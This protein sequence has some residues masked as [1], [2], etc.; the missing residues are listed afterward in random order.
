MLTSFR[1]Q[2]FKAFADTKEIELEPLTLLSG[3]NS[4][5]KSSIIQA[6]LLLKQTLESAP[7]SALAPG[8][9]RLLHQSLGDNFNDFVF[10]RPPLD[11]AKLIY[12]LSFLFDQEQDAELYEH[13]E[14][15][16][17]DLGEEYSYGKLTASVRI[18]F[19]WGAFGHR[20][21]PTVRVTRL[22]VQLFSSGDSLVTLLIELA[23]TGGTY[24]VSAEKEETAR[25]LQDVQ[26]SSLEVDGLSNFLPD[27]FIVS[28]QRSLLEPTPVPT[29]FVRLFRDCFAA[30]REDLSNDVYYL[31]SFR[32]PPSRVYTTGQ[33]SG[34]LLEPDG[35]NFAEVL[36]QLRD[37]GVEFV[38]P[39][40]RKKRKLPLSKMTDF[41]LQEVLELRQSVRVEQATKDIL[42]VGVE[43]LGPEPFLVALPDVGL[44]YNQILPVVIQGL[45]TPRGGLIIFEQPEIHLHPDV[46]AKLI[47]FFV[48]LARAGRRVLVETHSSHMVDSLCLE[49]AKDR[50]QLEKQVSVLFVNPPDKKHGSARI[51]PVEINRYGEVLNW[52][53]R[54]MPDTA[55]LQREVL[56]E[57][58]AKQEE[59]LGS[60]R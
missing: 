10:G 23:Q 49:I 3:V 58:I 43:T 47:S 44:G 2:N 17:A 36:W 1:V 34:A 30:L 35:S 6:L 46:Q 12:H 56:R 45:L 54:F 22:R 48:G 41:V 11:K 5:G 24:V 14:K 4:A 15:L 39:K 8:R 28:P 55:A 31:N 25:S 57:S 51:V 16:F 29:S 27:A 37:E 13:V 52:P 40:T 20:G 21:R 53:S 33:T 50:K 59:E 38:D 32:E 42:E 19:Q 9:G 7:S 60:R 18:A 26:F